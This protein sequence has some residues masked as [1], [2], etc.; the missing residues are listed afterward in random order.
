VED[1]NNHWMDA[2]RYALDGLIH[3]RR[4]LPRF[5]AGTV[6]QIMKMD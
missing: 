6:R 4:T 5:T 3:N 1:A 2:L